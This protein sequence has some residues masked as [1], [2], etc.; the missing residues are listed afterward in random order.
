[1]TDT[2][3]QTPLDLTRATEAGEEGERKHRLGD[4][5]IKD[6]RIDLT[7]MA[8]LWSLARVYV[9]AGTVPVDFKG[10]IAKTFVALQVG[11]EV[12]MQPMQALKATMLVN[13]YPSLFGDGPIGL[14]LASGQ[15]EDQRAEWL[16]PD[17]AET[18]EFVDAN[19]YRYT[20]KRKGIESPSSYVFTVADAKRAGL[21]GKSTTWTRHPKRMLHA[22]A[23]AFVLRDLFADVLGGYSIAEEMLDTYGSD[24]VGETGQDRLL[25]ALRERKAQPQLEVGEDDARLADDLRAEVVSKEA[26]DD[27]ANDAVTF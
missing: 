12:G 10:D 18:G 21:W 13:G 23:R 11:S 15:M 26:D 3:T 16:G 9:A 20:A 8:D 24:D 22:R 7:S 5:A 17:P 6:G 4:I 19:G 2:D 27:E 25:A 1:M 14:V